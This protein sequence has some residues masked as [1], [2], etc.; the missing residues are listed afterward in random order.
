[1]RSRCVASMR[2]ALRVSS[3]DDASPHLA[4][5]RRELRQPSP[6]SLSLTSISA[7]PLDDVGRAATLEWSPDGETLTASGDL[8]WLEVPQGVLRDQWLRMCDVHIETWDS[9]L[10][11]QQE[12]SLSQSQPAWNLEVRYKDG[13]HLPMTLYWKA[14]IME[15][16]DLDGTLME[17]DGSRMYAIVHGEV[18]LIQTFVFNPILDFWRNLASVDSPS[19]S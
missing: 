9:H 18:A 10:S 19:A 5:P 13:R 16:Y 14:P 4:A 6:P 3:V 12:D 1:M 7:R 2:R 17:H 15:E 11:P 8:Q